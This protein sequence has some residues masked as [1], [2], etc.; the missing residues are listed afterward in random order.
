M[1]SKS[2]RIK[3]LLFVLLPLVAGCGFFEKETERKPIATAKDHVLHLDELLE[4]MPTGLSKEDSLLFANNFIQQW[5]TQRL[6]LDRAELNLSDEQKNVKKQLDEYRR[7]LI[8]YLYQTEWVRQHMDT[9]VTSAEIDAYFESNK[10]DFELQEDIVRALFVK[11][12]KQTNGINNVGKWMRSSDEELRTVLEDLA[13]QHALAMHLN[14]NQWIPLN[15]LVKQF[16]VESRMSNDNFRSQGFVEFQDSSAHYFVYVKELKQKNTPA[17]VDYIRSNIAN[18]IL[19]KRKL[20]L[21]KKLEKD[22]FNEAL[23]KNQFKLI[24]D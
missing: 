18:I 11:F 1:S 24:T 21:V 17:P 22:I 20:E 14:E 9:T 8:I 10:G 6:L 13:M 4:A 23:N 19:N 5:A 7:S 3:A 2:R 12:G 16:P 15:N